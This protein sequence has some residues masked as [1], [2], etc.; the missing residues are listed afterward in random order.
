[1][2]GLGVFVLVLLAGMAM[3][4]HGSFGRAASVWLVL[5]LAVQRF[6]FVDGRERRRLSSRTRTYALLAV[7]VSLLGLLTTAVYGVTHPLWY[8]SYLSSGTTP[9]G[10]SPVYHVKAGGHFRYSF[11]LKNVGFAPVTLL[12]VRAPNGDSPRPGDLRPVTPN[13]FELGAIRVYRAQL[14]AGSAI[15]FP[16]PSREERPRRRSFLVLPGWVFAQ[17]GLSGSLRRKAFLATKWPASG[18]GRLLR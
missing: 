18:R 5:S 1:M 2:S 15:D 16:R 7:G 13:G 12:G 10:S 4:N 9:Y 14:R 6:A 3:L 8:S 11:E 17:E